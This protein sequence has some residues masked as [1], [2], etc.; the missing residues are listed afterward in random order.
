[1]YVEDA[2]RALVAILGSGV[3]GP[4]NVATGIAPSVASLVTRAAELVGRPDLLRL[5]SLPTAPDDPPRLV[6]DVGRLH[7]EVGWNA[8]TSVDQALRETI[9]Y[10]R[11][12]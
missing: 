5:G 3:V 11:Q 10:W 6:A 7:N 1:M 2:G 4:V 9:A 8:L 12:L